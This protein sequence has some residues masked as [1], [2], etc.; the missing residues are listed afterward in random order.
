MVRE[1][2]SVQTK[3]IIACLS[4]CDLYVTFEMCSSCVVVMDKVDIFLKNFR[5]VF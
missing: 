1:Q 4:V 5:I 2:M 3:S